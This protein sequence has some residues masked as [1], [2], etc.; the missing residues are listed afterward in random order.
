MACLLYIFYWSF[1]SKTSLMPY[2]KRSA[3]KKLQIW[4]MDG[5]SIIFDHVQ[6]KSELSN[7]S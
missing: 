2:V 4:M 7:S 3:N 6:A 1:M 5:G